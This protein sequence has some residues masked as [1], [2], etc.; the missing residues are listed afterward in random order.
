MDGKARIIIGLMLL[1][2]SILVGK[3]AQL[4][5]FSKKYK[6]QAQRT[7]LGKNTLFPSRGLIY[8]RDGQL[9][10]S[11]T[12][13]YDIEAI[14]NNVPTDID[15]AT[16]C[17]LLGIDKATFIKNIN[18]DWSSARYHKSIP[19][20]FLSKV[21]PIKFSAFQEHL[22]RYP[23][24]YPI[25]RNIRSYPHE[26]AAHV[27]GFLGE[28]NRADVEND[29]RNVYDNGDY[30]G[31]SGLERTYESALRGDKGISYV[32]KDNLGRNLGTFDGGSLDSSAIAGAD[33]TSS[34]DLELQSYGERLMQGKIGSVVAIE[35]S[36][37]EILTMI[38]SP[39]YDP[40]NLNL[41]KSRGRFY[42]SLSMDTIHRPL[43]D[44]SVMAKYPPGSIFKTVLSLIAMQEEVLDPNRTIYCDGTYEVDSKGL[45]VQ[46]CHAHPTPYN[47]S[48][49]LQHSCNSYYY[50]VFREFIDS[51]GYRTPEIGLQKILDHLYTF[52]LG[53]KLGVDFPIEE[54]G[55]PLIKSWRRTVC[56]FLG[57]EIFRS[58]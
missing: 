22:H 35:P 44:R 7:T 38:S 3:M 36:T 57:M 27:L 45:Y 43:F 15:T 16:F 11:N 13:I 10:V 50:Q 30:I 32:L 52:G 40:N 58:G 48:I 20:T 17:Q 55:L 5:L 51:H 39:T 46:K 49:A 6:E 19:F 53:D 24:F 29:T 21:D 4:Q 25:L 18:K 28:V 23:G 37:G 47:V 1:S 34:L 56:Y 31:R 42:D 33:I 14:F 54:K 41:N 26:H 2:S 12:T 9:L 8:D